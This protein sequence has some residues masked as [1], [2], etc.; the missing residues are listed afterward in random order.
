MCLLL[1]CK[2]QKYLNMIAVYSD[3]YLSIFSSSWTA[4]SSSSWTVFTATVVEI[5]GPFIAR[6]KNHHD[7]SVFDVKIW[8]LPLMV[9]KENKYD[10]RFDIQGFSG[11][12]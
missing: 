11:V 9:P 3:Y 8:D 1:P 12:F 6:T 5:T 10:H 7:T 2:H 4:I